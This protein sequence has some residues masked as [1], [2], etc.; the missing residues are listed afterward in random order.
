MIYITGDIH[1]SLDIGKLNTKH[2][3]QQKTDIETRA[4]GG[5]LV[6]HSLCRADQTLDPAFPPPLKQLVLAGCDLL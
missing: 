5:Q 1:G 6:D 3:P 4:A 2:F